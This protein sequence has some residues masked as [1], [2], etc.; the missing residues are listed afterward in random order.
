LPRVNSISTGLP[1]SLT[2][3]TTLPSIIPLPITSL[4]DMSTYRDLLRLLCE[5]VLLQYLSTWIHM[6]LTLSLWTVITSHIL[7]NLLSCSYHHLHLATIFSWCLYFG[8][9][10][11]PHSKFHSFPPERPI[12]STFDFFWV[13]DSFTL[14]SIHSSSHRHT[15]NQSRY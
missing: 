15:Q 6:K 3:L 7:I 1:G 4:C 8:G 10:E 14:R 9:G 2:V 11:V 13:I 5:G 12:K